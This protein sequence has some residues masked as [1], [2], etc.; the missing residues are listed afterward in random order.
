MDDLL[1]VDRPSELFDGEMFLLTDRPDH[2]WY[3]LSHQ[4]PNEVFVFVSWDSETPEGAISGTM[5]PFSRCSL[6]GA[7]MNG[8]G[9]KGLPH[10]AFDLPNVDSSCAPRVSVEVRAIVIQRKNQE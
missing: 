9:K 7:D 10:S 3:Y 8:G 6:P 5:L 2:E 1:A 4:K